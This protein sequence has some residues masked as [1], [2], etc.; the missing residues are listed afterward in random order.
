MSVEG[1]TRIKRGNTLLGNWIANLFGFP[2]E[3]KRMDIQVDID[4]IIRNEKRMEERWSRTFGDNE[5]HVETREWYENGLIFES[6]GI[7]KLGFQLKPIK[8]DNGKLIGF[9]HVFVR[10]FIGSS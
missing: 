10:A 8:D 7:C 3:T 4:Y 2:R 6:V 9:E 1:W 5:Y